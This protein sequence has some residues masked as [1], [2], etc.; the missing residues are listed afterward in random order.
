MKETRVGRWLIYGLIERNSG[1]LFYVGKTHKRREHRLRE[2]VEAAMD[3]SDYPVHQHIRRVIEA[4]DPPE[5][6]VLQVV[7]PTNSW[8]AAER[9]Q[10]LH[11]RN[12]SHKLLPVLHRAQTQK[13]SDVLIRHI[14]LKNV[15]DGG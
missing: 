6:F 5:I 10:I 15:R 9:Q 11:W 2:H 8:Q 7:K 14:D 3:G 4:G 12:V 1:R 13:S